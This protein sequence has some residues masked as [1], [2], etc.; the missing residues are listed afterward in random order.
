MNECKPMPGLGISLML[1]MLSEYPLADSACS[2]SGAVRMS[3][4]PC[5][6][7]SRFVLMEC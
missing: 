5:G 3:M 2:K 4:S 1:L 6:V 7:S